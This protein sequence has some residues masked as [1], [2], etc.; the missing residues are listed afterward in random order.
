[1]IALFQ[2]LLNEFNYDRRE[3]KA[4]ITYLALDLFV[5]VI[6]ET[7]IVA[8]TKTMM[9]PAVAIIGAVYIVFTAL[10]IWMRGGVIV[11]SAIIAKIFGVTAGIVLTNGLIAFIFIQTVIVTF[12]LLT[13]IW[14]FWSGYFVLIVLIIGLSASGTLA[15]RK[16]N[17]KNMWTTFAILTF[18]VLLI[19]FLVAGY[20]FAAGKEITGNL[21][22]T[23]INNF[24]VDKFGWPVTFLIIIGGIILIVLATKFSKGILGSKLSTFIAIILFL[25]LIFMAIPGLGKL[26][27]G[28]ASGTSA[29]RNGAPRN[30]QITELACATVVVPAGQMVNTHMFVRPGQRVFFYQCD[31]NVYYIHGDNIEIPVSSE[32]HSCEFSNSDYIHLRGGPVTT[33]VTLKK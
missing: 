3:A 23:K 24:N 13:P 30:E 27:K 18:L 33:T 12:F 19:I 21:I 11:D 17:W 22:Q 26:T 28:V 10:F 5:L 8:A 7:S 6:I 15:N 29:P 9:H 16:W 32:K 2:W 20:E 1:M 14:K 31:P 25:V 4:A